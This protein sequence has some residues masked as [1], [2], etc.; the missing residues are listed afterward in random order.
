MR[1]KNK[2]LENGIIAFKLIY[3]T[4]GITKLDFYDVTHVWCADYLLLEMR[5]ETQIK[6]NDE[7]KEKLTTATKIDEKWLFLV[8]RLTRKG[9]HNDVR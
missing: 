5:K 6:R 7:E 3:G 2:E 8:F 1:N 4:L 9:F